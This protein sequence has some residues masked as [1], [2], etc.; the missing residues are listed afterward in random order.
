MKIPTINKLVLIGWIV[1]LAG[2]AL[3]IYGYFAEGHPSVI[4]WHARTPWWIADAL[5]N[6]ESEVGLAASFIGTAL[7][8]WPTKR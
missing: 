6:V 1:S 4:D 5:P 8:Y 7:I 2:I 3:W